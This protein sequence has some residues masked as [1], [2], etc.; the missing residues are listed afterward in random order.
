MSHLVCAM[1]LTVFGM[2]RSRASGETGREA[3]VYPAL[4]NGLRD[5]YDTNL[6]VPFQRQKKIHIDILITSTPL[7]TPPY[8]TQPSIL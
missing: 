6:W 1:F 4:R 7:E 2:Q 5:L 8:R 3:S